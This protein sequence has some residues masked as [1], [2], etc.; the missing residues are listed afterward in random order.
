MIS[1]L[2]KLIKRVFQR[3][4][5]RQSRTR[6]GGVTVESSYRK[7]SH[8]PVTYPEYQIL[9]DLACHAWTLLR[10]RTQSQEH[11]FRIWADR[12]LTLFSFEAC[13]CSPSSEM[14]CNLLALVELHLHLD[15]SSTQSPI[16]STSESV[17]LISTASFYKK[18]SCTVKLELRVQFSPAL[19][20]CVSRGADRSLKA[21]YIQASKR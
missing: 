11:H 10:A 12:K 8:Q 17:R 2:R 18:N 9:R 7:S 4:K 3:V 14:P 19:A 6:A 15:L 21:R 16:S 13:P 20:R 5:F 1:N